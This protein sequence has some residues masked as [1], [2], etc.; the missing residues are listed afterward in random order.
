M[1]IS[2]GTRFALVVMLVTVF[3]IVMTYILQRVVEVESLKNYISSFGEW[4]PLALLIMIILASSI[5]LIFMVPVAIAAVLLDIRTALVISLTGLIIGAAISFF[6]ARYIGRDY[7]ERRF[8][9]HIKWLKDYDHH[10]EKNGFLTIFLI[11]L[12]TFIPFEIVNIAAGLS[13]VRFVPYILGTILGITPGT[14]ICIYFVRS[15]DDFFSWNFVISSILM[16]LFSVV[17]LLFRKVREVVFNIH[18]AKKGR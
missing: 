15:T 14:I 5:G 16:A 1:K 12:I 17:P 2:K 3:F 7:V 4:I 9:N 10:L 13:R 8:I 6:A 18:H 11:R